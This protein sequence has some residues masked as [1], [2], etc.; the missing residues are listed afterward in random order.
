LSQSH[1][2]SEYSVLSGLRP[3][4]HR[5]PLRTQDQNPLVKDF[6]AAT[7][8][9]LRLPRSKILFIII[10]ALSLNP[11]TIFL[12]QQVAAARRHL[13][14]EEFLTKFAKGYD[15]QVGSRSMPS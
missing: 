10:N 13:E 9:V 3:F 5:P 6:L 4:P 2:V 1:H 12:D 14:F 8:L 11:Y 7:V 15:A